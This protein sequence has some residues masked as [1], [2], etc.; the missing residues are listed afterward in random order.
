VQ[1][2]AAP[3][4]PDVSS[5]PPRPATLEEWLAIPDELRAE[6]IHGRIVYQ[7]MPGPVHGRAQLGVGSLVRGP[8]DRRPG[9]ADRPGGWWISMEVDL[10]IAGM[11]CRPDVLGWRRDK[12]AAMPAASVR[13]VVTVAPDWICEVLS[14]TTAHLDLGDKRVGYHRAEVAHYWL[15]DP[16]NETLTVL[17]WT[18]AGYLVDLVAGRGEKVHAAPFEAAEID[19]SELLDDAEAEGT[20]IAAQTSEE[21]SP[22][23]AAKD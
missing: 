17:V 8:Y 15:L 13:G 12:H 3:F 10:E 5:R 21:G 9:G 16:H 1:P 11:G 2:I 18:P 6:L 23:S 20:P 22:S 14:R 4:S 7:G 19:V